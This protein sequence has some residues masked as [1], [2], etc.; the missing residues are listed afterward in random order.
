MSGTLTGKEK[1]RT[2]KD[3]ADWSKRK[4]GGAREVNVNELE[5]WISAIGGGALVAYGLTRR[6]WP[7]LIL[8]L[9]GGTLVAR[10]AT[11]HCGMYQA[12]GV[13]TNDLGRR[14][15]NTDRAVKIEQ[16]ITINRPA[17]EVYRFW[18]NFENLPKFMKHVE[19]VVVKN[20]R[21]SH[22]V[23]KA[24]L[25]M[26]V[27]W[28]AEIISEVPNQLI[29]WRSEGSGD[30]DNAGS[31]RFMR[32]ADG[33]TEVR[34]MLQ[35]D[36]PAGLVGVAMAKILGEEPELHVQEDLA[37]FKQVMETGQ[38]QA[39]TQSVGQPTG[40]QPTKAS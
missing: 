32:V 12:L 29:G 30:V 39:G 11:G 15:V 3:D 6:S 31:V 37:R 34:V 25:G 17:E 23:A 26:K 36:P 18:R 24:P 13:S 2:Y 21:H 5:R 10:G 9:I 8:G 28:D 35:Y 38:G 19:S 7:G 22:W 40:P 1:Y 20:D 4:S 16:S 27:E 33:G 14:K